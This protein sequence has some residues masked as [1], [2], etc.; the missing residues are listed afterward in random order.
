VPETGSKPLVING[1]FVGAVN[2]TER[3]DV[4]FSTAATFGGY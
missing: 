3:F 1:L 2:A 4:T